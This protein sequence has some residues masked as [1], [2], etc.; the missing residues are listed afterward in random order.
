MKKYI[1]EMLESKKLGAMDNLHRMQMAT[2]HQG[3]DD[4][5]GESGNTVGQILRVYE[6]DCRKINDAINWLKTV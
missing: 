1:L 6:E 5:Y 4:Q 3:R 2:R